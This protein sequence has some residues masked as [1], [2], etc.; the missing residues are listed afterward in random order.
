MTDFEIDPDW[1]YRQVTKW[2]ESHLRDFP[3]R[4]S[5]RQIDIFIAE[6]LLKRTTSTA[7]LRVYSK[8][9][10]QVGSFSDLL[11]YDN[12]EED[13]RPVGLHKQRGRLLRKGS[14]FI[15]E[16]FDGK[17]P[18]CRTDLQ[19]IPGVGKYMA[20]AIMCF[21]YG[22]SVPII[23]SNVRRIMSRL[24]YPDKIS[25]QDTEGFLEQSI[26]SKEALGFNYGLLDI[27]ALLCT[28]SY[29]KCQQC[30]L[31]SNCSYCKFREHH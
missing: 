18:S 4:K 31:I 2:S 8:L 20:S 25:E 12:M 21:Y 24:V 16:Q 22:K 23:D 3:W 10:K 9:S 7:A 28:P 30:P 14:K 26:K 5:E 17:L 6:V 1:L 19:K 11:H 29:P 15:I 13:L 27:G